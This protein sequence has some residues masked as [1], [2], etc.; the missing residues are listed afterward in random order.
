M[1][2][3]HKIHVLHNHLCSNLDVINE[4]ALINDISEKQ[5]WHFITKFQLNKSY[6]KIT[7]S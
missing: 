6:L 7:L 3:Y 2:I 5:T 4:F 1:K